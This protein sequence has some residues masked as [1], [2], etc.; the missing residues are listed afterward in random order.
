MPLVFLIV[1]LLISVSLSKDLQVIGSR[2]AGFSS[3]GNGLRKG[4][5]R[6]I[7]D[8]FVYLMVVSLESFYK[9]YST[10][11]KRIRSERECYTVRWCVY[12]V[13]S[14]DRLQGL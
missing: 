3:Q 5:K 8:I 1:S 4:N 14:Y 6:N 10:G 7:T 13:F 11:T 12:N 9:P 2:S